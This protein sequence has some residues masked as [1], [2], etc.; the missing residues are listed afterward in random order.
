MQLQKNTSKQSSALQTPKSMETDFTLTAYFSWR[1]LYSETPEASKRLLQIVNHRSSTLRQICFTL[2]LVA[3]YKQSVPPFERQTDKTRSGCCFCTQ[4]W[5]P[6]LSATRRSLLPQTHAQ[7]NQ[8]VDI[9]AD[10]LSFSWKAQSI[11]NS[12]S[13]FT[14]KL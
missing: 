1:D 10:M 8:T 5:A 6:P 2:L 13:R 14:H 7:K 3:F 12:C 9:P 11:L 4:V